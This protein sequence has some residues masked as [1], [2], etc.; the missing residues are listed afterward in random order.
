MRTKL[1]ALAALAATAATLASVAAAGPVAV[2][3]R[4]VFE[5]HHCAD[6]CPFVLTPLTAGAVK[7]DSGTVAWCCW[8][9]RFVTRD[10]QKAEIDS[11]VLGTFTG[12][13]GTIKVS[14]QIEWVD[15]PDG[16]S[17]SAGTWKVVGG[18]GVYA[19][20]SGGG[21]HAGIG[22]PDGSTKFREDGLVN[23]K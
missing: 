5:V 16:Y 11:P 8:N 4:I 15:I 23:P 9:R 7:P 19:G 21:L 13:R 17:T 22:L 2:K 10:G 12:K 1:T 6:T 14:Q 18:T 3:Q 20:L